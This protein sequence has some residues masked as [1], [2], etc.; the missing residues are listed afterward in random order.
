[1]AAWRPYWKCDKADFRKEPSYDVYQSAYKVSTLKAQTS[2]IQ[3]GCLAAIL[4]TSRGQFSKGT[5]VWQLSISIQTLNS[6]GP[7]ILKLLP[8]NTKFKMAAWQPYWIC[9]VAD[10]RK[11]PSYGDY[12]SAYKVWTEQ[13]LAFW[14]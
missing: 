7:S 9:H 2:K 3:D 14:S 13:T 10:F 12:Q 4:N 5:F 8:E 6:T 1:M 11:E